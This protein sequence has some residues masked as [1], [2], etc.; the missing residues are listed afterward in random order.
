[1]LYTYCVFCYSDRKNFEL[2]A[3]GWKDLSVIPWIWHRIQICNKPTMES[4]EQDEK[5]FISDN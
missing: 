4:G 3:A 5:Q 1:M 2:L